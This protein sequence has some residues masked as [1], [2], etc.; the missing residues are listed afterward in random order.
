MAAAEAVAV[1]DVVAPGPSCTLRG[2]SLSGCRGAAPCV[3][4]APCDAISS[5]LGRR[6]APPAGKIPREVAATV[7]AVVVRSR[8]WT[9]PLNRGLHTHQYSS[10]AYGC[11]PHTS[12]TR[13]VTGTARARAAP[14]IGGAALVGA[15]VVRK[16]A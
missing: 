9:G 14:S 6:P 4:G 8:A 7:A 5:C 15:G 16:R 2:V 12:P 3:G 13:W 11:Q 10:H 1:A